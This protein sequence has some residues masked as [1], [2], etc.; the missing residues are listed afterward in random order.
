MTK[1]DM[2]FGTD[3]GAAPN[4][5]KLTASSSSVDVAEKPFDISNAEVPELI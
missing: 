2:F 4:I 1:I 3:T 5:A